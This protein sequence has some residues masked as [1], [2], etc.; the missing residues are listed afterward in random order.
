[1]QRFPCLE[2]LN[3][4][5]THFSFWK[6]VVLSILLSKNG[7]FFKIIASLPDGIGYELFP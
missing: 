4:D 2:G 7:K 5:R 3:A 1:M 6:Y